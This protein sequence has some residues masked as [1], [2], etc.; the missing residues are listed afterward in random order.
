MAQYSRQEKIVLAAYAWWGETP[1]GK[2]VLEDLKSH[3]AGR[4]SYVKGD[5]YATAFNEGRRSMYLDIEAAIAAGIKYGRSTKR[6]SDSTG[7]DERIYS[8]ESVE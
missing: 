7:A 4:P 3:S 6:D 5:P 2:L 8:D 1:N